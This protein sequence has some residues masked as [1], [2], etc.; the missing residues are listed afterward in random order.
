MSVSGNQKWIKLAMVML[1]SV[2]FLHLKAKNFPGQNFIL[3]LSKVLVVGILRI[4]WPLLAERILSLSTTENSGIVVVKM[5]KKLP[6]S[7]SVNF[8][9]IAT[10][11]L[12]K[13][14]LIQRTKVKSSFL[15]M[16]RKSLINLL[17]QCNLSL[18]MRKQSIH[19][20]SGKVLTSS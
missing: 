15:N 10:S 9:T 18:K 8:L 7:K 16:V 6:V 5:I 2:F 17:Q 19:L 13:I 1:S 11:M 20:I 12:L 4:L 14:L 3:T